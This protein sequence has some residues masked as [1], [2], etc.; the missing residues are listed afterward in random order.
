MTLRYR[1]MNP[2]D[3][4][5]CVET[6]TAHPD[7]HLQY[8]SESE[9]LRRALLH[10][11]GSEGFR[12]YVF[13]ETDGKKPRHMGVGAI[14]FLTDA[15]TAETKRAP[16]FWI[17]AEIIRRLLTGQT[18]VLSDRQVRAAN[19]SEGLTVFAWPL[20]FRSDD[21]REAEFLN[22]LM[23]TFIYE[24]RGYNLKEFIGQATV[25][26][27]VRASLNSGAVL[28]TCKGFLEELPASGAEELLAQPHLVSIL[29]AAALKHVGAWSTSI[30]VHTPAR[31]GFS[32]SEQRLLQVALEGRT[33]E[34]LADELE[35][36]VSAVKK[37]WSSI[38]GR[39]DRAALG[40]FGDSIGD[41]TPGDRG[42]EKKQ[43]V[44][45]Y[46][47]TR[48]EELRPVDLKLVNRAREQLAREYRK[49]QSPARQFM[50]QEP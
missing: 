5:K 41:T 14:A 30:F 25:V 11:V 8:D 20:G 43:R 24:V 26:E 12:A 47:R 9:P 13:E 19:S 15:F 10:L 28:F 40:I 21:C 48:P 16:Y 37:A 50:D 31:I 1:P 44:L 6:L 38:Y 4:N 39:V 29:R 35:I 3:V 32:H 7:F 49:P 18:P 17:G 33:D 22:A 42:K 45:A 2:T 23:G 36:S 46:V 27:G 34:E